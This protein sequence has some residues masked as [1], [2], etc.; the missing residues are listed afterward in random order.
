MYIEGM[1]LYNNKK[2]N[3]PFKLQGLFVPE[4]TFNK[5]SLYSI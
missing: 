3:Q 1:D 5:K 2:L 4:K